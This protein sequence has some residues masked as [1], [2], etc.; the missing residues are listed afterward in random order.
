MTVLRVRPAWLVIG[1]VFT[2]GC[3]RDDGRQAV[4]GTVRLD[5]SSLE[6]GLINFRPLNG[7]QGPSAGEAVEEGRFRIPAEAG[8]M[9][10]T[11]EVTIIAMKE[12]GR[13]IDDP[14]KGRIPELVRIRFEQPPP[15][16]TVSSQ[17]KNQFEFELRGAP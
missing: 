1:V 17:E 7:T 10:G 13:V 2:F 4:S 14:Q 16:V 12:T 3:G 15:Q 5:G 8:L 11:Y 6:R 9:P